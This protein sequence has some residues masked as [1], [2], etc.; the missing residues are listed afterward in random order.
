MLQEEG[1]LKDSVI[2]LKKG[3]R[4]GSE[5]MG[6]GVLA[7]LMEKAMSRENKRKNLNS[8][9]IT[10]EKKY[11]TIEKSETIILPKI[12][13]HQGLRSHRSTNNSIREEA[14]SKIK[15]HR[16]RM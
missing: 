2:V 8:T 5:Q 12:S 11:K 15:V 1:W 7:K 6:L 10:P 9:N 16:T 14:L 3:G 13:K 4:S